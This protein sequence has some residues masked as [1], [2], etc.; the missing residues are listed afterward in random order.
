MDSICIFVLFCMIPGVD[1]LYKPP[2]SLS[3]SRPL[4]LRQNSK[5]RQVKKPKHAPRQCH[6][7]AKNQT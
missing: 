3:H 1:N 7:V 2:L 5:V 4:T 6:F